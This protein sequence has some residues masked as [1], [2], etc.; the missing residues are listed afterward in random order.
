[1]EEIKKL[2]KELREANRIKKRP[3][4]LEDASYLLTILWA[5]SLAHIL[6]LNLYP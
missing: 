1:M 3:P 4:F 6:G 5:L 2:A